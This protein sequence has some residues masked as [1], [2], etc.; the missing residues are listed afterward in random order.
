MQLTIQAANVLHGDFAVAPD[1]R[2]GDEQL[3]AAETPESGTKVLAL[4]DEAHHALV[5][6][7]HHWKFNIG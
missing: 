4:N 3:L 5:H 2:D 7:E 6:V 1:G